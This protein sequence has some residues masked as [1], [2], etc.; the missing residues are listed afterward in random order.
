VDKDPALHLHGTVTDATTGKPIDQFSVIHGMASPN[1]MPR[2]WDRPR[3][4]EIIHGGQ[5][6][7]R[8]V[9]P[10]V[11]YVIRIEADG[12]LRADSRRVKYDEGAVAL[13]LKLTPCPDVVGVV[14]TRDGKPLPD[15]QVLLGRAGDQALVRDGVLDMYHRSCQRTST[16]AEG[17]FRLFSPG[18]RYKLVV[19]HDSAYAEVTSQ[20][21][22][23]STEIIAE[24]WGKLRG[25]AMIGGKPAAGQ[26]IEIASQWMTLWDDEDESEVIGSIGHNMEITADGE[27]RFSVDHVPPSNLTAGLEVRSDDQFIG[28]GQRTRF[29]VA[30]GQTA[31]LTIGGKGRPVVGRFVIPPAVAGRID[32]AVASA[33]L[34]RPCPWPEPKLPGDWNTMTEAQRTA[35]KEAWPK[36]PDG[37][38]YVAARWKCLDEGL[39]VPIRVLPDGSFRA[40]DLVPGKYHIVFEPDAKSTQDPPE[41]QDDPIASGEADFVVSEMPGGRSDEALV[42]PPIAV[43]PIPHVEIGDLAPELMMKTLGEGDLKLSQLRGKFVLLNFWAPINENSVLELPWLRDIH[44]K[45]GGDERFKMINLDLTPDPEVLKSFAATHDLKW[46][47][48]FFSKEGSESAFHTYHPREIPSAWLIGPDGKVI[49]RDLV[50]SAIGTAVADALGGTPAPVDSTD[51][52]RK[53]K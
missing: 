36:T 15:A 52:K 49:A 31:E 12:Y 34:N 41:N 8:L 33:D 14:R 53:N 32:W 7:L 17:R 5:F 23:R 4:R 51:A 48:G 2:F 50:G 1:E 35:W 26:R 47:Q 6:D 38:G 43:N 24:P 10:N 27:G 28:D 11:E 18:G 29:A 37:S 30:P 9:V 13:D 21:R 44:T 40:D 42:L 25:V 19:L 45:F 46:T 39:S 3:P 20:Q 22:G 16:D